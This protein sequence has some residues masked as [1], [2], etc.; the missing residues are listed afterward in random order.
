MPKENQGKKSS[1]S[2]IQAGTGNM[3]QKLDGVLK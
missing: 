2:S 3:R 1:F